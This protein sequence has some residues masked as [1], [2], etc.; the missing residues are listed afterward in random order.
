MFRN[1]LVCVDGSPHAE[2]A[3]IQ[4]IDLA[5]ESRARLTILTSVPKPSRWICSSALTAGA[6]QTMAADFEREAVE[7]LRDAVGRVPDSTPVTKILTHEPIRE[8]LMHRIG[9]GCHDLLVMGSR[10]H[11]PLSSSVLGSVSRYALKHSPVPVL[12]VH[13][14]GSAD[15]RDDHRGVS[16]GEAAAGGLGG[17]HDALHPLQGP[18]HADVPGTG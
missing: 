16:R 1:I 9:D 17:D 7:I 3:L 12:V 2:R 6:Y 5:A 10:G 11:G 8:A 15:L 18:R 14:S 4:A 13:A